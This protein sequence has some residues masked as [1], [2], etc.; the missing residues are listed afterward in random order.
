MTAQPV[1][2]R[3]SKIHAMNA[4]SAKD[5]PVKARSSK[6]HP[7]KALLLSEKNKL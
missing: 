2:T 4:E 7:G 1:R 6:F 3:P 5:V